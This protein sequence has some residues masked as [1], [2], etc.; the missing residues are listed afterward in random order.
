L[1]CANLWDNLWSNNKADR[2]VFP[3]QFELKLSWN[4][5]VGGVPSVNSTNYVQG[6]IKIDQETNR[7]MMD[8]NFSTLSLAPQELVSYILDFDEKQLYLKQKNS[9]K[10]FQIIPEDSLGQGIEIMPNIAE[11]FDLFPYVMYYNRTVP[12]NEKDMHE[13]KYS[14]PLGQA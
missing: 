6:H 7:M 13:F 8:T 5:T 9:C 4:A 2:V 12:I 11:L 1:A 10:F 14:Y 3:P